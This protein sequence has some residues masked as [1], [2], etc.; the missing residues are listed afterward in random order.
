[1]KLHTK[2]FIGMLTGILAG[3]IV[4][5]MDL[6][7]DT[8]QTVIAWVKPVGD[9]FMRMIFM[10]VIPLILSALI[11][12]I[13]EIGDLKRLGRM[14]G[15]LLMYTLVVSSISVLIGVA[16]VDIFRPGE[17]LSIE[18]RDYLTSEFRGEA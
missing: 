6:P 7:A 14:G 8:L 4:K 3:L 13:A 2:I 12:G 17:T 10:M 9:I 15:R 18:T 1:M 16:A 5:S 11:L